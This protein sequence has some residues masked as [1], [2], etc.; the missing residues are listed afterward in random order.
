MSDT[1][2]G[3]SCITHFEKIFW[4]KNISWKLQFT[5]ES[6]WRQTYLFNSEENLSC[7][8]FQIKLKHQ[9]WPK[10][11]STDYKLWRIKVKK[12]TSYVRTSKDKNRFK[13]AVCVFYRK[14]DLGRSIKSLH[15]FLCLIKDN[16]AL[17]DV[18]WFKTL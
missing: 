5:S 2:E 11:N 15:V 4:F 9:S 6:C 14:Q 17:S 1:E 13:I 10:C 12:N 3:K 16:L 18:T 8:L 7:E